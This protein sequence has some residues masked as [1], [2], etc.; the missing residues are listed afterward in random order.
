[1]DL[2]LLAFDPWS[3]HEHGALTGRLVQLFIYRKLGP[4]D[5]QC[6]EKGG[7]SDGDMANYPRVAG[8]ADRVGSPL[9]GL[10]RTSL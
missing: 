4:D 10:G 9:F 8:V 1:V 3:V 5:N 6:V 2:S 7:Q